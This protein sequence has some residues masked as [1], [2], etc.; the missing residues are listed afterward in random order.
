MAL[1][2]LNKSPVKALLPI[3]LSDKT[4]NHNIIFATDAYKDSGFDEKAQITT[5]SIEL[6]KRRIQPRVSKSIEAQAART[7]TKAEVFTRNCQLLWIE[8]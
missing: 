7:R 5:E 6:L 1:I 2:E 3:L 4:T 8:V